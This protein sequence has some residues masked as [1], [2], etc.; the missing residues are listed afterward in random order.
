MD[1]TL[2]A[3]RITEIADRYTTNVS[4]EIQVAAYKAVRKGSQRAYIEL[5]ELRAEAG[6]ALVDQLL[7]SREADTHLWIDP[8]SGSPSG[9]PIKLQQIEHRVRDGQPHCVMPVKR[10]ARGKA[11][12]WPPHFSQTELRERWQ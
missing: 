6:D 11:R 4:F 3:Q 5:K 9:A 1:R 10:P 2:L 12:P 7:A 8:L